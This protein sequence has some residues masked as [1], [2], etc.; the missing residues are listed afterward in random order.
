[1]SIVRE[2]VNSEPLAA[3]EVDLVDVAGGNVGS[4]RRCL[5]RLGVTYKDVGADSLPGGGRPL[6]LPGVGA[7]GTV[8][9]SLRRNGLEER[10]KR[11]VADG[12]PLLGVCIGMQVL[13]DGSE[14][15]PGVTGLS[16]VPGK[17]VRFTEGKVPQIGW[18]HVEPKQPAWESG[19]V[20]FVN[21][22]YGRPE[23][24]DVV[25]YEA[26]YGVPFC[27]AL[28]TKNITAFQFHPEKSGQFGASLL[29]RWVAS[30]S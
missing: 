18:N 16:L 14:E 9:A 23:Q 19:F 10:I 2:T 22:F 7:F 11:L 28:K 6:I 24:K 29:A 30:V 5:H 8:M 20:Y 1:M 17:V 12:T 15:A 21:S 13:F 3:G 4:V 27:A 25:L 26:N